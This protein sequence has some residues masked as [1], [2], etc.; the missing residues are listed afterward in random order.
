MHA[1]RVHWLVTVKQF[2]YSYWALVYTL[3]VRACLLA[4]SHNLVAGFTVSIHYVIMLLCLQPYGSFRTPRLRQ[5]WLLCACAVYRECADHHPPS[6]LAMRMQSTG[7]AAR[8]LSFW[9]VHI[10]WSVAG[11]NRDTYSTRDLYRIRMIVIDRILGYCLVKT[12]QQ[13]TEWRPNRYR[14]Q[15]H[16]I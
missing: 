9:D 16:N 14:L 13:S 8:M 12:K 1:L 11:N 4:V 15:G 2:G 6:L 10:P 5:N 3:Y 7:N